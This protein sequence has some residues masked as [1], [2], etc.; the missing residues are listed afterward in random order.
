MDAIT[1]YLQI[2]D[3]NTQKQIQCRHNPILQEFATPKDWLDSEEKRLRER[4]LSKV[5]NLK[6]MVSREGNRLIY[7]VWF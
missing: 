6:H 5:P 7:T 2:A 4:D 3:I 1:H